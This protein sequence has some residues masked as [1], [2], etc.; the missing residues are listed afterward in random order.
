MTGTENHEEW[1]YYAE[2]R[3]VGETYYE[4]RAELKNTG[5]RGGK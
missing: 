2:G 4:R 1:W 5:G 3:G